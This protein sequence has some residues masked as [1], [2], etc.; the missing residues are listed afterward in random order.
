MTKES[1]LT[2]ARRNYSNLVMQ[3]D[4]D[5]ASVLIA[6]DFWETVI[7]ALDNMKEG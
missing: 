4:T 5:N 3:G 7:K 6:I 2:L 1:A